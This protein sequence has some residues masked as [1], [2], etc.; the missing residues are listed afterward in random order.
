[1]TFL[2]P[3][4]RWYQAY[5]TFG[6]A[7][8]VIEEVARFIRNEKLVDTV[9]S[10]R[11]ERAAGQ[12]FFLFLT[13]ETEHWGTLSEEVQDTLS[14]C[15]HL[16][17]PIPEAFTLEQIASMVSGDLQLKSLGQS[18]EYRRVIRETYEDPFDTEARVLLMDAELPDGAGEKLLWFLSASGSGSWPTFR[19][20]C[21]ALG[22]DGSQ[23]TRL[24]RHLRLLGHLEVLAGG[25]WT[26]APPAV[27]EVEL[28][29]GGVR[30]YLTGARDARLAEGDSSDSQAGGPDFRQ[31]KDPG[32]RRVLHHPGQRLAERLPDSAGFRQTLE[33]LGSVNAHALT[34]QRFDGQRFTPC[35]DVAE[36]G[37][38]ALTLPDGRT[39]HALGSNQTWRRGEFFALRFLALEAMGLLGPWRYAAASQELAVRHEE[40]PPE[41]YERCLVLSS[42]HLPEHRGGWLVYR[43]VPIPLVDRLA[44][45]LGLP[46][47]RA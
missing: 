28:T 17:S 16:R 21:S 25:R 8:Q 23:A 41:L 14:E 30:R 6:R 7:P 40:R 12:Q 31:V 34:V 32:E 9:V 1:M 22:M 10:L 19:N 47:E 36:D 27:V 3:A 35:D 4:G 11:V 18:L 46:V 5:S 38:Y 2:S 29:A 20:A 24:A 43:Q 33:V 42:G 15:K 26:V 13:L 45:L 39:I 44:T 37:L